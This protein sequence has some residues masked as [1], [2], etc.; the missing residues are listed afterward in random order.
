MSIK[1]FI[2]Y[3]DN[4]F[5][6]KDLLAVTPQLWVAIVHDIVILSEAK[7]LNT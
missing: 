4:L 7:N 2:K 3:T 1:H 6:K 5:K